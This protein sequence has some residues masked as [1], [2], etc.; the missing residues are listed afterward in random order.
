MFR[1]PFSVLMSR[2]LDSVCSSRRREVRSKCHPVEACEVKVLLDDTSGLTEE[3]T[4]T[5]LNYVL[6]TAQTGS[7]SESIIFSS[8]SS[9]PQQAVGDTITNTATSTP[10]MSVAI[11]PIT[12]ISAEVQAIQDWM[13][14]HP[15]ATESE[16]E[17]WV[18]TNVHLPDMP[19]VDVGAAFVAFQ[20]YISA[21]PDQ[22][23]SQQ[24][25]LQ[26]PALQVPI[27]ASLVIP[28]QPLLQEVLID[29]TAVVAR[30]G[31]RYQWDGNAPTY[32]G[33]GQN[34][35]LEYTYNKY[36]V[37]KMDAAQV[38]TKSWDNPIEYGV[39]LARQVTIQNDIYRTGTRIESLERYVDALDDLITV[40]SIT[41]LITA[42]TVYGGAAS[43]AIL[44][45]TMLIRDAAQKTLDNW[46]NYNLLLL[47]ESRGIADQLANRSGM[48]IHQEQVV[49]TLPIIEPAGTYFSL[50][51]SATA[52]SF[53]NLDWSPVTMSWDELGIDVDAGVSM[54][55]Q[56]AFWN[57][58]LSNV[59]VNYRTLS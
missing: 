24:S 12:S 40:L 47:G 37:V 23:P 43:G 20:Q 42:P 54:H 13:G 39:K 53:R 2:F 8:S 18:W 59:L 7:T 28:Q 27:A 32:T 19:D 50:I 35:G 3:V 4:N 16:I 52:N 26:A 34:L 56:Q 45:Q 21:N 44:L 1:S 29:T 17:Q 14:A 25:L 15:N 5:Y 33:D 6:N 22:F 41:T 31:Y 49:K 51:G 55:F 57:V 30:W 38:I 11:A 48:T 9:I 46:K 36:I 10:P 58:M